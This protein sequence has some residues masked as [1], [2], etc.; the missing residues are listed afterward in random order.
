M[1]KN[2]RIRTVSLI[3]LISVLACTA[4][5]QPQPATK[6]I[7][8]RSGVKMIVTYG[9]HH[10]VC[11]IQIPAGVATS[12]QITAALDEAVPSSVRGKEWNW[13]E[14]F[15]GLGGNKNTYYEHVIVSEQ[16]FAHRTS[17]DKPEAQVI[18]K[19]T[20]CGW[21]PGKDVFDTPPVSKPRATPK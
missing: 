3:P 11:K 4:L 12:K 9:P 14:E 18:F 6:V 19:R 13:M 5:S 21:E 16:E 10:Q 2:D 20:I 17:D 1:F 8:S 7:M 15:V